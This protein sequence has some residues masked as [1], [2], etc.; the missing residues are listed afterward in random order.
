MGQYIHI[1]N[2]ATWIYLEHLFQ[3]KE[4]G[5]IYSSFF[6]FSYLNDNLG[7]FVFVKSKAYPNRKIF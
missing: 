3:G 6:P 2:S 1:E 7:T 5:G 4:D